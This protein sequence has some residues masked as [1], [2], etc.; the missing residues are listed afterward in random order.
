MET[1]DFLSRLSPAHREMSSRRWGVA[2][3]NPAAMAGLLL[4]PRAAL[5]IFRRATESG[6]AQLTR[7]LVEH[8]GH[9]V[10]RMPALEPEARRLRD[11]FPF[12][13]T[14]DGWA[15][16]F[17]LATAMARSLERERF[18][19]ATLVARV[20]EEQIRAAIEELGVGAIGS[21]VR[22]RRELVRALLLREVSGTPELE[23]AATNVEELQA[24]RRTDIESVHYVRGSEG[25]RYE[26]V[27]TDGEVVEIVPREIAEMLGRR[28]DPVVV[29]EPVAGT[30]ERRAATVR[31]PDVHPIGALLT[32]ATA[33]AAEEALRCP[34]FRTLVTRRL[35]ERRVATRAG[36]LSSE[37]IDVLDA[38][39]FNVSDVAVLEL[40]GGEDEAH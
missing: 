16:P 36:R 9:G 7:L 20:N 27:L 24:I 28:F 31:M 34:E 26:I 12:E 1:R 10:P 13:E 35:D 5:R 6:A 38:L 30:R 33:R 21:P 23:E 18:F 14:E 4:H 19:A 22:Q 17:D 25:L 37:A 2:F 3:T 15:M 29:Q 11:W 32:F 39:G 40:V 8:G